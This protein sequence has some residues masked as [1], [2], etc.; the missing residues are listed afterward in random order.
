MSNLTRYVIVFSFVWSLILPADR[1]SVSMWGI[2]VATVELS[3]I[4]STYQNVPARYVT[5]SSETTALTSAIFKVDN[6]YTLWVEPENYRILFF[7]K[8]TIQ[9]GVEN[10]ISTEI[11]NG[12]VIYTGTQIHIPSETFTIFSLLDFI[13]FHRFDQPFKC[14]LEREGQLFPSS[15]KPESIN[16]N[17]VRYQLEIDINFPQENSPIIEHTDIF[18]WA[19]YKDGVSR[20][21][22]VNYDSHQIESCVFTS[23]IVR[24]TAKLDQ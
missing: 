16:E 17:I 9:P 4:D 18:T 8:K 3:G 10:L 12:T 14:L 6:H 22:E 7:N 15:L 2:P 13:R 19:V 5:F 24:L 11:L 1:Y 20:Y 21:I 23:G